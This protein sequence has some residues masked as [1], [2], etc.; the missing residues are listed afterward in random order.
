MLSREKTLPCLIASIRQ[1][2]LDGELRLQ[3]NDGE[4]KLYWSQGHLIYLQ[5]EVAGEQFGNYLLRQGILD[6]SALSE[7]LANDEQYRLGE[8]VVQWGMMSVQERDCHL[9]SLQEQIMIH[10]L[11]HEVIDLT[12]TSGSMAIRLS[13]DLHFKLDH[14]CFIWNTF[15]EAHNQTAVCDLLYEE[16]SWRWEGR[17]NLLDQLSDLPLNPTTAYALSFLGNDPIS[18]ETFLSLSRLPE[19]EAASLMVTLWALGG[20]TLT[21]GPQ[22]YQAPAPPPPPPVPEPLPP[23]PVVP[24]TYPN[25]PA[26]PPGPPVLPPTPKAPLAPMEPRLF[27]DPELETI[28]V[29]EPLEFLETTGRAGQPAPAQPQEADPESLMDAP[30]KARKLVLKAKQFLAQDRTVEAIRA[31]E[32]SVQL[33]PEADQAY[34]AWLLL[35]RLRMSNPAWSTRS[36]D[37]LQTASRL[38][39]KAAE[40]WASMGEVY[41]RKGFKANAIACFNRALELDPSVPI[42]PD[43]DLQDEVSASPNAPQP[44]GSIFKRFKAMLGRNDK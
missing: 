10:A 25:V 28:P 30:T 31:L 13:I 35:G 24:L 9:L 6:F 33:D 44:N 34:E 12:W 26:Q 22:P 29:M 19:E 27:V 14:R 39:I 8:K 36:I 7:L 37:A 41:Y 20:L 3:Q 18:F 2:G 42:P 21:Q 32:Q 4:R 16:T 17:S 5:S 40:P 15:Q 1:L 11:E 38:R 23:T 43:V